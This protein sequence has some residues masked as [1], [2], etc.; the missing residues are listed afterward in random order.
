MLISPVFFFLIISENS[1][2]IQVGCILFVIGA[3]TDWL[4]GWWARRFNAAT[5]WGSFIDPLADKFLTTSAFISFV[6]MDIIP[7][8]MV[9]IIVVRDILT[10]LM[11]IIADRFNKPVVTSF[12][13]KMKTF[14]QMLFIV[15]ILCLIYLK[16]IFTSPDA[17]KYLE[18][19]LHSLMVYYSMLAI[20][21]LTLWTIIEYFFQNKSLISKIN[22]GTS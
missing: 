12:S 10:T 14:I 19:S 5:A 22:C 11:R 13:A 18:A 20:T 15:V 4:D 8:W 9:L 3:M 21:I 2:L 1:I 6:I 16:T 7:L 17:L